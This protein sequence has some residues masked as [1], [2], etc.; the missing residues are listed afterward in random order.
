[1][2]IEIIG[3]LTQKNNGD[4]KL[5]DLENVDYDGTG[6]NAKQEIE[7]KI[8]DVKNSLDAPTIKSDIQ[9]LKDNKI[10]LI[11]DETSMEGIS[12]TEHDTLETKDKRIIGAI[13][14]VNSQCKDIA[15]QT[16]IEG[17]KIYLAK[18]DG[19]KLD[20][21]TELPIQEV[22]L[23]SYVK[24]EN[25]KSLI[26]DAERNKLTNLENY[27]DTSIKNDMQI[28]K[29]RMDTFTSLKEGSTTGDAEL[30]DGRIGADGITYNNIGDNIRNNNK[31]LYDCVLRKTNN[32][33]DPA[34]IELGDIGS[35]KGS[36]INSVSE[37]TDKIRTGIIEVEEGQTYCFI[38]NASL[39]GS[40]VCSLFDNS[41]NF[42]QVLNPSDKKY[43]IPVELNIKYMRARFSGTDISLYNGDNPTTTLQVKLYSE[44]MSLE[45][46][47]YNDYISIL[48]KEKEFVNYKKETNDIIY[49]NDK[50]YKANDKKKGAIS[51]QNLSIFT[52]GKYEHVEISCSEG[53]KYLISGY[54]LQDWDYTL[55][56]F[57]ND[58][59]DVISYYKGDS[60][61]LV[62]DLTIIVPSGATKLIVNNDS[63]NN[64]LE[65][66]KLV[67]TNL[68]TKIIDVFNLENDN[69]SKMINLEYENKQLENRISKLENNNPFAFKNF[70]K[71]Y[72]TFVFDDGRYDWDNLVS[73][74]KEFNIKLCVA[75]PPSQLDYTSNSLKQ[76][77]KTIKDISLEVVKNG[78]EV[79]CHSMIPITADNVNDN[80][81]MTQQFKT[82]KQLLEDAGFNVRGIIM[83]G[84]TGQLLGGSVSEGGKIFQKW[85]SKYY[86]YSDRYGMTAN[87]YNPRK[88]LKDGSDAIIS[89]IQ[90]TI[91]NKKWSVYYGH[92]LDGSETGL[93]ETVLRTILQ[94]CVDNNVTVATYAEMYDKFASTLLEKRLLELEN[95]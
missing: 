69:K 49:F 35:W 60:K 82:N 23:S 27:D 85:S 74:F 44:N 77:V 70:D 52:S 93:D 21:G 18:S 45:Y 2:G 73:I 29:T 90:D 54:H 32:L 40:L 37:A 79:L 38:R 15:K 58:S 67:P 72:V 42:V 46:E 62:D 64:V 95:K 36:T 87:Y 13:N 9:D 50:I 34:T 71:G 92:T 51:R 39:I 56:I 48:L 78:G 22:D 17:D 61:S 6:K 57:V 14:E 65:V 89:H 19:T 7:K 10:N 63:M 80:S 25:G 11:E 30:V 81:V 8:E 41:G 75:V 86:D 16:I 1:M 83:A 47:K 12:D 31:R 68:Q 88:A 53:E 43:T 5:V 33:L 84:G 91:A 55:Y 94:Y 66:Y 4:F 28:Q 26:T 59:N 76:G 3:K 24:K 20:K